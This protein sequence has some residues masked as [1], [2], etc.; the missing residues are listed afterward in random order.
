MLLLG[1]ASWPGGN[2]APRLPVGLFLEI[3]REVGRA[4]QKEETALHGYIRWASVV[5]I[6]CVCV[7]RLLGLYICTMLHFNVQR[8]KIW[9][10]DSLRTVYVQS[11]LQSTL[12]YLGA[13]QST[14]N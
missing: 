6:M 12:N 9:D 11:T 7:R 8:W 4:R 3:E 2:I 5:P 1:Y 13:G 10:F 14:L